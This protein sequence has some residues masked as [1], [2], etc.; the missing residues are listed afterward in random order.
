MVIITLQVKW[1]LETVTGM[2]TRL[3]LQHPCFYSGQT[4]RFVLFPKRP[5]Q[6]W[7]PPG[8]IFNGYRRISGCSWPEL[9]ADRSATS[10]P[11]LKLSGTINLFPFICLYGV[12]SEPFAFYLVCPLC[13]ILTVNSISPCHGSGG[14]LPANHSEARIQV[15]FVVKKLADGRFCL[16]VLRIYSVCIISPKLH[17]H[18]LPTMKLTD[19]VIKYSSSLPLCS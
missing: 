12:H 7:N 8:L 6:P 9:E 16:L 15:G 19:S 2:V 14:Q 11:S 3:R 1:D 13:M 17:S 5:D 10:M 18:N 4:Q